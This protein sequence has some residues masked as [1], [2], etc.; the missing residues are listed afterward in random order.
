MQR[1]ITSTYQ[2]KREEKLSEH[3]PNNIWVYEHGTV[4]RAN[5]HL[6]IGIGIHRAGS[7]LRGGGASKPLNRRRRLSVR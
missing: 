3:F 4:H 7:V 2:C 6:R 1:L 5:P